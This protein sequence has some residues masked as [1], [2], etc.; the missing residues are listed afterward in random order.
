[1]KTLSKSRFKIG[2]ECPNKLYFS[3][4]EDL[5]P[6]L[7]TEDTFLQSLAQGGFQVEELARLQYPG[8]VIIDTP[9]DQYESAVQMTNQL[10]Q[11]ENVT[12][13]EAAFM[14]DNLFV[15]TDVLVKNG[16]FIKLIEVKAKSHDPSNDHAFIGKKGGMVSDWKPYLFDLAFQTHVLKKAHPQFLVSSFLMMADKSSR[17]SVDG[18]NQMFRIPAAG[19][20]DQRLDVVR[21]VS[22]IEETG[23]SILVE[24]PVDNHIQG[25]FNNEY[26]YHKS[27]TFQESITL[28]KE[29]YLSG[30][31]PSWPTDFSACKK[32]EFRANE[33]QLANGKQ[34]G[35]HYCMKRQHGWT[36]ADLNEPNAFEIWDYRGKKPRQLIQENRLLQKQLTEDDFNL[37]IEPYEITSSERKWIQVQ[38]SVAKDS[39]V[40]V[41]KDELKSELASWNPPFHFIDFETSA[42]A[43]PFTKGRAPYEQVAFQFS[44]HVVDE[45]GKVAHLDEFLSNKPGEFPNFAFVRALKKALGSDQGSVFM[46]AN[47]ENTILNAIMHQLL[48]SDESDKDELTEFLKTIAVSTKDNVIQWEHPARAIIDLRKVVLKYYY[49]PYTKGS[50]SIKYVLPA[51][52]QNSPFLQ[53]KYRKP[54]DELGLTSFNFSGNHI[55]LQEESTPNGEHK[56]SNPYSMLPKLFSG[57]SSEEL[58][59]NVSGIKDIADGGAALTA[60]AKL[61]YQD[62]TK[63]EREELSS[64]LKKYCELDTLAMVM[65]YEHFKEITH[66]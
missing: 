19:E 36:D 46:F 20:G 5:Y 39:S 61:Q 49:N 59:E 45:Q 10:L 48:E 22:S 9:H 25:I 41:M 44:H 3:Y 53:H 11:R 21:L 1:M 15:R 65:I 8:G 54:I 34:S 30:T 47:H 52:L 2:L 14:W 6:S 32:C 63:A 17:S 23:E 37:E 64:G 13:Y 50:N 43:L 24:V 7:K 38:K 55:W 4:H 16:N 35:F 33:E 27:L 58:E 42:V 62:M 66:N 51:V 26:T 18:L 31:Y 56:V 12:I 40:Y 29:T 57:W 28:L 60:Y